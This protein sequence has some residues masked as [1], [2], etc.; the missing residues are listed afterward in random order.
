MCLISFTLSDKIGQS[1]SIDR[2]ASRTIG[3][4]MRATVP[5]PLLSVGDE[6]LSGA[7]K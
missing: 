2:A 7:K 6:W 4:A 1:G 5:P 3:T